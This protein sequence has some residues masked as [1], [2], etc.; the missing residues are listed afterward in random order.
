[1]L[2]EGLETSANGSKTLILDLFLFIKVNFSKKII[3]KKKR[4]KAT[5][6]FEKVDK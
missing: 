5:Y 2:G 1:M 6:N 3:E 4:G